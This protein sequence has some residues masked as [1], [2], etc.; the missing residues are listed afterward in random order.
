[1]SSGR[2]QGTT[3][4]VL[5]GLGVGVGLGIL[6]APRPGRETR[7]QIADNVSDGLDDAIAQGQNLSR[8]AQERLD[9]ARHHVEDAAEAGHQAYREAKSGLS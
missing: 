5:I 3:S 8:L 6:L 4:G 7:K 9:D 2:W 1:M